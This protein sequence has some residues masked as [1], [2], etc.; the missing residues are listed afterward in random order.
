MKVILTQQSTFTH[1][2]D[3]HILSVS[4][5]CKAIQFVLAFFAVL[6]PTGNS[7]SPSTVKVL[8]TF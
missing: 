5:F 7:P 6:G 3:N 8:W 1:L 4:A 2:R